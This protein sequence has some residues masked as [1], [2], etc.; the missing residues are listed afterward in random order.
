M[1]R[2]PMPGLLTDD[3]CDCLDRVLQSAALTG[4]C[5]ERCKK[6]GLNVDKAIA[7]NERQAEMAAALKREFRPDRH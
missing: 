2:E 1:D 6:A 5:L 7:E 4:D 3:D